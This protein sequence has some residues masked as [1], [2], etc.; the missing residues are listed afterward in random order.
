MWD[1]LAEVCRRESRTIH[2]I[3]TLVSR[4]RNDLS[5]TAGLRVFIVSYFRAAAT[6]E[7]HDKAGHGQFPLTVLAA[8][9]GLGDGGDRQ[10]GGDVRDPV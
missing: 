5:L 7:G 6:Q 8:Q 1:A 9:S 3:C 10:D 2:E 4:H